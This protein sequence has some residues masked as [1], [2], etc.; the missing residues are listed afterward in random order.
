MIIYLKNMVKGLSDLLKKAKKSF[1]WNYSKDTKKKLEQYYSGIDEIPLYNWDK[2]LNGEIQYV[3]K[4]KKGN[5]KEDI[6]NWIKIYDEYLREFGLSK[7]HKKLLEAIKEKAL[8]ECDYVITGDK[9]KLTLIEMSESKLK[10]MIEINKVGITTEQTMIHVSKWVGYRINPREITVKEY[11]Y[12]LKEFER[13]IKTENN[14][15][16]NGKKNK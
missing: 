10:Q 2:C 15:A 13:A 11:F 12:L 6:E 4:E 3:R 8:H 1:V 16:N 9:F 14:I 7:L 5:K